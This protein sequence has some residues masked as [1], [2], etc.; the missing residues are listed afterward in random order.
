MLFLRGLIG[1]LNR[2][3]IST[4]ID[5]TLSLRLAIAAGGERFYLVPVSL[6]FIN[7]FSDQPKANR[8]CKVLFPVVGDTFPT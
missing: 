6:E 5:N 8:K 4:F 2:Q 1:F 3:G 7:V